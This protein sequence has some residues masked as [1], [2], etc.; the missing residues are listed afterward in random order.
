MLSRGLKE[1]PLKGVDA[2]KEE[3][4]QMHSRGCFKAIAVKELTRQEKVRAQEGLMILNQK[5]CGRVKGRLAY[6]GKQTHDW[7]TKEEKSSPTV[8]TE[9]IKLLS[10]VDAHEGRDVLSMDV[11]NA[12]IQTILPPKDDGER[13]IMKIRGKLV[14]WLVEIEPTAYL[15]LLVSENGSKVIYLDLL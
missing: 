8:L 1:F 4:K 5:R 11:P 7:I 14:D 13:V 12:F 3:L 9:S 2:A 10:T 15:S 6:N